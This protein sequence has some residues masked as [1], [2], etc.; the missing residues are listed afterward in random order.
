MD[1]LELIFIHTSTMI[2]RLH[3]L[4]GEFDSLKK[5][6]DLLK[7]VAQESLIKRFEYSIDTL[8]KY[9]KVYLLTKHG[10]DQKSPKSVFRE[11][12]RVGIISEKEALLA[13]EMADNRNETSHT[14]NEALAKEIISLIPKYYELMQ[15]IIEKTKP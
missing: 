15:N 1:Q 14:Y 11:C 5:Q 10:V 2:Q 7:L 12:L 6:S 13:L 3:E 4:L 9:L 8:W